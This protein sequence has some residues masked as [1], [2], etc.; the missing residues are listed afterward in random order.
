MGIVTNLQVVSPYLV[1]AYEGQSASAVAS[2]A[3]VRSVAGFSFP[4]FAPALYDSLGYGWGSSV[5]GFFGVFFGIPAPIVLW[6]F[7]PKLRKHYGTSLQV[8]G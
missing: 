3:I 5:L 4:L 7:G 1:E 2:V 6:Y 8:I